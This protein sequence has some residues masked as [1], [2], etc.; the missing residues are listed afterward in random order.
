MRIAIGTRHFKVISREHRGTPMTP[1]FGAVAFLLCAMATPIVVIWVWVTSGFVTGI[2]S[3][4][5]VLS[6]GLI[7]GVKSAMNGNR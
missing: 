7:I 5:G 3:G 6:A 2:E 4:A 1:Q